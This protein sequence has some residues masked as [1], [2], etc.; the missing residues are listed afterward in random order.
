M[1]FKKLTEDAIIPQYQTSGSVGLD[2][3]SIE[4]TSI[5]PGARAIVATGLQFTCPDG[6]EAQ[7]RSRSGLAAKNG[8]H[9]LNSPGTIDQDYTG[10]LKV[11]LQNS[12]DSIFYVNVG[13]RIA[14]LVVAPVFKLDGYSLDNAREDNG[15]GSTGL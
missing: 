6:T 10:E 8:V 4:A 9:V 5:E 15:F 12:G 2:L 7:I 1:T 11:I 14:Q 13:D 3:H